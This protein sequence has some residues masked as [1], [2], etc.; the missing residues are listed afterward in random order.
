M[1]QLMRDGSMK[2][3]MS[4]VLRTVSLFF[5]TPEHATYLASHKIVPLCIGLLEGDTSSKLAEL[6]HNLLHA[7]EE[8]DD[9]DCGKDLSNVIALQ[10][11]PVKRPM[12]LSTVPCSNDIPFKKIKLS[13]VDGSTA[14]QKSTDERSKS[15]KRVNLEE[16]SLQLIYSL[17]RHGDAEL[18]L[19]NQQAI[20]SLMHVLLG[21]PSHW[22]ELIILHIS[23]NPLFFKLFIKH[24]LI[25]M[26]ELSH[27]RVTT[28][29]M[30]AS[31]NNLDSIC[32][33]NFAPTIL[34]QLLSDHLTTLQC[35]ISLC[36]HAR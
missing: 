29:T 9:I 12:D 14:G 28:T 3:S 22:C 27:T 4:L 8:K 34:P 35:A 6:T 1:L 2:P 19:N 24:M 7:D 31:I 15:T 36:Y 13:S 33:S 18:Q 16:I 20:D 21:R 17:V 11:L 30:S 5:G 10:T 25:P 26:L 23:K 32:Q